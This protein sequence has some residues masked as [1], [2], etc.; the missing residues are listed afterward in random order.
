MNETRKPTLLIVDDEPANIDIIMAALGNDYS[1]CVESDS[2]KALD[3]AKKCL[4]DLILLDIMMPGID[5]FET[6]RLMKNDPTVRDVP[7]IFLTALNQYN[8]ESR[9]L[10]LGA[11]DYINKPFQPEIVK[12]RVRCHLELKKHR[13]HLEE[14]VA[15][16]TKELVQANGE[17]KKH[18]DHLEKLVAEQTK[19]L[20]QAKG[21]LAKANKDLESRRTAAGTGQSQG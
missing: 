19:E 8:V 2:L 9:G 16:Q 21:E 7:I 10:K 14:L 11:A 3:V 1:V 4:P 18:C 12:A 20:V 13:D 5:G 15:A 17:L 6:C